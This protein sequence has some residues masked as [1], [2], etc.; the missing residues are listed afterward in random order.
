M[1]LIT[2]QQI[3]NN[4]T[5]GGNVDADMLI[6]LLQDAEVTTLEP[7]LGTKLYDKIVTD[8]NEG[9]TNNLSGDYLTLYNDYIIKILCFVVYVDYMIDI[10]AL[11][12]NTGMYEGAP[13]NR[14]VA[15]MTAINKKI[16]ANRS[17]AD[18]YIERMI[19]FLC[20][21]NLPEY[22]NSQDNDYDIDPMHVNMQSGWYLKPSR[23]PEGQ[24]V[25]KKG[26][27]GGNFL[28]LE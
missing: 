4:T 5:I 23:P 22:D 7:A 24:I 26:G 21:K 1:G 27:G 15:Q 16:K 11:S 10:Q 9:G 25:L 6:P 3:K 8:Y 19:R 20:D 28:E 12:Q 2:I 18:V 13:E 14:N 17:K